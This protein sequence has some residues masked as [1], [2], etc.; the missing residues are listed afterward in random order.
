MKAKDAGSRRKTVTTV[1]VVAIFLGLGTAVFI[2]KG[3]G[4]AVGL[5]LPTGHLPLATD[6]LSV[7]ATYSQLPLS[8]EPTQGQ[9]DGQVK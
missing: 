5:L 4:Q 7:A 6:H 2:L 3:G 8:L 1:L 9:T